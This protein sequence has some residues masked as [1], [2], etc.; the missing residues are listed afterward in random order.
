DEPRGRRRAPEPEESE[1][2]RGRRRVEET[3]GFSVADLLGR[4]QEDP[5]ESS[6]SGGGRRRRRED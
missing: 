3:G 6:E 2:S 4:L 1:E 5:S